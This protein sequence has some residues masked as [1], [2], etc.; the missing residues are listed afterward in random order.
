MDEREQADFDRRVRLALERE[1]NP[2]MLAKDVVFQWIGVDAF[3]RRYNEGRFDRLRVAEPVGWACLLDKTVREAYLLQALDDVMRDDK[4]TVVRGLHALRVVQLSFLPWTLA[5]MPEGLRWA[6]VSQHFDRINELAKLEVSGVAQMTE[7]EFT[8]W[9]YCLLR[10]SHWSRHNRTL[11]MCEYANAQRAAWWALADWSASDWEET[12]KDE[13]WLTWFFGVAESV[14]KAGIEIVEDV[15]G[16]ATRAVVLAGQGLGL[17]PNE[18]EVRSHIRWIP[19][20][21]HP[22]GVREI[23]DTENVPPL[24]Q[25]GETIITGVGAVDDALRN[26][27]LRKSAR[28]ATMALGTAL[29]VVVLTKAVL[30]VGKLAKWPFAKLYA[31]WHAPAAAAGVTTAQAM[32]VGEVLT[33]QQVALLPTATQWGIARALGIG[34]A[35]AG[36]FAKLGAMWSAAKVPLAIIGATSACVGGMAFALFG[37]EEGDQQM[38]Y[39][40]RDAQARGE[41]DYALAMANRHIA[42]LESQRNTALIPAVGPVL[43]FDAYIENA[44]DITKKKRDWIAADRDKKDTTTERAKRKLIPKEAQEL[45]EPGKETPQQWDEQREAE[46]KSELAAT[47]LELRRIRIFLGHKRLKCGEDVKVETTNI[48]LLR[49]FITRDRKALVDEFNAEVQKGETFATAWLQKLRDAGYNENVLR[50][51]DLETVLVTKLG[52]KKYR[53]F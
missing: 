35:R 47:F 3:M 49:T 5:E 15:A 45:P 2:A 29:G 16:L 21:F 20:P 40:V 4:A 9:K 22:K 31:W 32:A 12:A 41:S 8:V 6:I 18:I 52:F 23:V 14:T 51:T 36:F 34:A 24:A 37:T 30:G 17:V 7:D 28:I 46:V 26:L 43:A 33:I 27:G 10:F 53:K 42:Q 19:D 50:P 39:H 11:K 1:P 25:M 48:P 13:N 44:I 38:Q